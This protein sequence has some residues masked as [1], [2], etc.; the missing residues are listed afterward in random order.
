MKELFKVLLEDDHGV[1]EQAFKVMRKHAQRSAELTDMLYR[2]D[3]V[4][5]RYFL[6]ESDSEDEN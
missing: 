2:C 6:P 1:S 3:A 5:G 4:D